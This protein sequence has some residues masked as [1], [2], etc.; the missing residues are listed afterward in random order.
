MEDFQGAILDFVYKHE[1]ACHFA[2]I[3]LVILFTIIWN[4]IKKMYKRSASN[5]MK[6]PFLIPLQLKKVK[7]TNIKQISYNTKL[8]TFE[9]PEKQSLN[10]P[11]GNI[12]QII[13]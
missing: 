6:D 1:R 3:A 2:A 13:K 9:I 5:P 11:I 7:L 10:L 4:E 12:Q 8:L